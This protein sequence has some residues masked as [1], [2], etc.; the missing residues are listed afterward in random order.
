[1][2]G[3]TRHPIEAELLSVNVSHRSDVPA[4][5]F[6]TL[7]QMDFVLFPR[8]DTPQWHQFLSKGALASK[9]NLLYKFFDLVFSYIHKIILSKTEPK[10]RSV[11]DHFDK[12]DT[13]IGYWKYGSFCS[14][15]IKLQ[16]FCEIFFFFF[17]HILQMLNSI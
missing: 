14:A 16:S 4:R 1:M 12:N 8:R 9:K 13:K 10:G 2:K 7:K 17:E 6:V 3:M 15:E 11:F 5:S